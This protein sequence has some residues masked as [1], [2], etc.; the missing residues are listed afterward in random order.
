MGG[1]VFRGARSSD[2]SNIDNN[3]SGASE[4]S[5]S[6]PLLPQT[7]ARVSDDVQEPDKRWFQDFNDWDD[8]DI[9]N[10]FSLNLTVEQIE[11]KSKSDGLGKSFVIIQCLWFLVQCIGR[12]AYGIPVTEL[13]VTCLAFIACNIAMYCFWWNKPLSLDCSVEIERSR[14]PDDRRELAPK[15][16]TVFIGWAYAAWHVVWTGDIGAWAAEQINASS[17]SIASAG[18]LI[19]PSQVDGDFQLISTK[20]TRYPVHYFYTA[21]LQKRNYDLG[22]TEWN[23]W[24]SKAYDAASAIFGA[25][26]SIAWYGD[27]PSATEQA[28]WRAACV[29]PAAHFAVEQW[30]WVLDQSSEQLGSRPMLQLP[31]AMLGLLL[32]IFYYISPVLNLAA[33]FVFVVL[34]LLQLRR[35]PVLAHQSVPWSNFLPHV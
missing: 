22:N 24:T 26:H 19:Y 3:S 5:N 8:N 23:L 6:A 30:L 25:L 20:S 10:F 11:D 12:V 16:R 9:R 7:A 13:E 21:T 2:T 15:K 27:F 18:Y 34:P 1:I 31:L 17:C 33:R 28:I 14:R 29:M 4:S 32:M 35:L